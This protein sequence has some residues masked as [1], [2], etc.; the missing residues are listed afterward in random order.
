MGSADAA[1]P[2]TDA[3]APQSSTAAAQTDAGTA[4]NSQSNEPILLEGV[5]LGGGD[6]QPS[7]GSNGSNGSSQASNSATTATP[8]STGGERAGAITNG[9]PSA[10]DPNNPTARP[11]GML[12]EALEGALTGTRLARAGLRFS[13]NV[14]GVTGAGIG[15]N[16]FYDAEAAAGTPRTRFNFLASDLDLLI[17]ARLSDNIQALGE[18]LFE[19]EP[20]N[21]LIFDVERLEV[22]YRQGRHFIGL[23]R[24][25][26][27]MGY[28][29]TAYH[30]GYWLQPT[31][32]RPRVIRF[33]DQ[34][35]LI[36]AH[37][38]GL[39]AGTGFDVGTG[40]V[41]IMLGVSNGRQDDAGSVPAIADN[42][43]A[44]AINLKIESDG[45]GSP[46]LRFGL[47]AVV[48]W[49]APADMTVRPVL[50]DQE[51]F[52]VMG[53]LYLAYR[54]PNLTVLSEAYF[55]Q[56]SA[57]GQAWRSF[58]AFLVASYRFGVV[59]PYVAIDS[60]VV[61]Q[62]DPYFHPTTMP[63]EL[64][65]LRRAVDP[66]AGLRFHTGN[67]SALKVEYRPTYLLETSQLLHTFA[68]QW[69]FGI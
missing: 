29:N 18:I 28:W 15:Q 17:G 60:I 13:L 54:G 56:H 49:I 2:S 7:S 33:E 21:T 9:G 5:S 10:V 22:R 45:I 20:D 23:G 34:G 40:G 32:N 52:Q 64:A 66:M 68:I 61:P 19:T 12:N 14:F 57:Q 37:S 30:H 62:N 50:P 44:K 48:D 4:A 39:V 36:Q 35:G 26:V 53:N 51:I 63:T 6:S 69:G 25:H 8:G 3:S 47:T 31:I 1:P 11:T 16:L 67:W 65:P 41:N 55:L 59:S 46:Y 58:A 24:T 27:E 43:L 42:N 38:I